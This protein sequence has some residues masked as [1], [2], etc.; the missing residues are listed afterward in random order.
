MNTS[1]TVM[2]AIEATASPTP[3]FIFFS[4]VIGFPQASEEQGDDDHRHDQQRIGH[5][6]GITEIEE[7]KAGAKGEQRKGLG[8][9]AGTAARQGE[10]DVEQLERFGEAQ[11]EDDDDR[12][13]EEG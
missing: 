10:R 3:I 12:R 2:A 6:A 8:R 7:A 4:S 11:Q 9:N 5:G 1:A 13:L